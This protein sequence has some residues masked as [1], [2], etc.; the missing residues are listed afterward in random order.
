[1]PIYEYKALAQKGKTK[2]GILDADTARDAR[3]KLRSQGIHV[4]SLVE[5]QG[6]RKKSLG[7]PNPFARRKVADLAMVTRQ[8][9]TLIESG[10]PL[11]DATGAM[12]DQIEDRYLQT[13]FRDIR[14]K[15]TSGKAF[16][17]AL[18]NHPF[19]FND[20]YVHMIRAGEAAGTLD[21]IL[22]RLA[23]YLQAQSRMQGKIS[24]ALAYPTVMVVIGTA[25]VVFLMT[26]VIPK[27]RE[28]LES[29]EKALPVPTKIVVWLSEFLV[30][31]WWL[32]L[33][34][35]VVFA[36]VFRIYKATPGGRRHYDM[37][38]ISLPILGILFKKQ[39]ISRFAITFSTL[40][41]SGIPALECL[42]ILRN[43]VDN[44]IMAQTLDDVAQTIIEGGDIATP[45]RKSKVFPSIVSYMISVGEKAGKMETV[46][47]KI[48][49][50]YD[51]EIEVTTQKVASLL[52]PLMIVVL[53]VVVGF[54]I[55]SIILPILKMSEI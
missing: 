41:K 25:V 43:V 29:Q 23:D 31:W 53:S 27:I 55:L 3:D 16:A 33:F 30:H 28:V 37:M 45:L 32:L 2:T 5:V 34:G 49:E 19:Y 9:A 42:R 24:A 26:S 15:I 10:I 39:A 46:L 44:V 54:I 18:A 21:T 52:E 51:E 20:L 22:N 8:L 12:I 38:V 6:T 50:T 11:R 36:I 13:A 4:V 40:L 17:D 35:L 14:E 48:A 47:T 7:I 1:M